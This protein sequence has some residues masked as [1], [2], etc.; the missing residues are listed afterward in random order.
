MLYR[1]KLG[2]KRHMNYLFSISV[3]D[4]LMPDLIQAYKDIKKQGEGCLDGPVVG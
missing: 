1:K 3:I 4:R 2:H